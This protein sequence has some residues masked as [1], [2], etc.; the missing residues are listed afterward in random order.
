[1]NL[2]YYI[3]FPSPPLGTEMSVWSRA[4]SELTLSGTTSGRDSALGS[5]SLLGEGS[6]TAAEEEDQQSSAGAGTI[7]LRKKKST[8]NVCPTLFRRR[9]QCWGSVIFWCG[10][11]PLTYGS[12]SGPTPDPTPF[13][14]DFKDAKKI[15]F[16]IFFLKTYL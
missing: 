6:S 4:G 7:I 2:L 1:M 5:A 13:F 8:L 14:S 15:I 12:E 16:F 10:S 3:S 9:N 11:V